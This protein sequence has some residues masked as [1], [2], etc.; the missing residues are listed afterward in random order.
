MKDGKTIPQLTND[1]LLEEFQRAESIGDDLL[2]FLILEEKK[3]R[4]LRVEDPE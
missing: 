2:C 3:K 1:E 4:G